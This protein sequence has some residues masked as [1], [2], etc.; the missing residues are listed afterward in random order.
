MSIA[1]HSCESMVTA[2]RTPKP[3]TP[4]GGP[5]TVT[6]LPMELR[7]GDQFTDEAGAWEV[8]GRPSSQRGGKQFKV[9]VQRPGQPETFRAQWWPAYQRV[10]IARNEG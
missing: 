8:V 1:L 10:T 2:N 6:A 7:L 9:E 3:S 5:A 4:K